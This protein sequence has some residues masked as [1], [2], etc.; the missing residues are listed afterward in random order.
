MYQHFVRTMARVKLPLSDA[1]LDNIAFFAF[2]SLFPVMYIMYRHF[3]SM[4]RRY[5]GNGEPMGIGGVKS[6]GS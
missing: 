2:L 1:T 5:P 4:R 3:K 6:K